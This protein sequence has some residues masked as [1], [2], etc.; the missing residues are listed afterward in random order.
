M[1]VSSK[2]IEKALLDKALGYETKEV[3]EEY[4]LSGDEFVLQKRKT[5]TKTYPPD[6]SA[7]QILLDRKEET[8]LFNLTDEQLEEEKIKLLNLLKET[9]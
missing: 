8:D 9:K 2:K 1:K 5:S 7:L 6:L 4:G 3:I